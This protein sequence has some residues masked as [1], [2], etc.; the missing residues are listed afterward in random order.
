MKILTIII[1]SPKVV[2][3][4]GVI[5]PLCNISKN[6]LIKYCPLIQSQEIV[7]ISATVA[8]L[9]VLLYGHWQTEANLFL[10]IDT[11]VLFFLDPEVIKR[12]D[13]DYCAETLEI[14]KVN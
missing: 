6:Y 8:N 2:S 14:V 10:N 7:I 9:A 11:A 5:Q 12:V 13:P 4:Y 3:L 1:K